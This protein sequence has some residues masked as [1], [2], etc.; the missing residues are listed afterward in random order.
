MDWEIVEKAAITDDGEL[1]FPEKLTREFLDRAKRT[2]GSYLF[3]NQYMNV[4]VPVELQVFKKEWFHYYA[5]APKNN[6]TFIF[7]DPAISQADTADFTGVVVV[8]VDVEGRWYI[9]A[10]KRYKITPTQLIDLLFEIYKIFEPKIIGIEDVAYQKM[11]LYVLD[12][13]MR[14][15]KQILPIKGIRPPSEKNKQMRIMSLMPRFEWGSLF[16]NR[17]LEDLEMELL[18][19][20]RG[21]HDDLIDAL[22]YIEYIYY[23]PSKE[24]PWMKRPPSQNHP[25][26]ESWFIQ[27]KLRGRDVREEQE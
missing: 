3:A 15:R 10:A 5:D 8:S 20:P 21:R 1:L 16:L 26:Y 27:N 25:E 18:A 23:M 12:E 6:N 14:R 2:M 11:I 4:I 24:N 22:A 7:V 19:F 9:K 17:G 13:E